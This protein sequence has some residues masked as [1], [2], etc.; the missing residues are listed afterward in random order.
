MVAGT[1][2]SE[3]QSLSTSQWSSEDE[4]RALN[5]A[6]AREI[7]L[8]L[9]ALHSSPPQG[10]TSLQHDSPERGRPRAGT[11]QSYDSSDNMARDHSPL[12][13]PSA[14]FARR[15][16][17]PHPYPEMTSPGAASHSY[18]PHGFGGPASATLS[19][20]PEGQYAA[21]PLGLSPGQVF[22][23]PRLQ[24]GSSPLSGI[25]I[26]EHRLPS[27][28]GSSSVPGGLTPGTR[29]ISAAA[30][31]KTRN[32]SL[33]NLSKGLPG[34]PYPTPGGGPRIFSASALPSPSHIFPSQPPENRLSQAGSEY[35]YI[36]AYLQPN[37]PHRSEFVGEGG[38]QTGQFST[39]LEDSPL[40]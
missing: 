6:A 33:D 8:E 28:N 31:K 26:T 19:Q 14:P 20:P 1:S 22:H 7:R 30:F 21:R 2:K 32:M 17:S 35:D 18:T 9:E 39:D 12:A 24:P 5:A 23:P 29:T 27:N 40:R 16:L 34:S 13:P 25:S 15:S 4:V 10:Q 36:D 38:Y 37:S 3:T 11:G